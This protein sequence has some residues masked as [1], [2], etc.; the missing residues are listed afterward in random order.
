ML[1]QAVAESSQRTNS[2]S[3]EGQIPHVAFAEDVDEWRKRI[4]DESD[5]GVGCESRVDEWSDSGIG[6]E[7]DAQTVDEEV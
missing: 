2:N 4:L 6:P 3:D 7:F 1:L 5:S